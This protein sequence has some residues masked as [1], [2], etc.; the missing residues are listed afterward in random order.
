MEYKFSETEKTK[1]RWKVNQQDENDGEQVDHPRLGMMRVKRD[2]GEELIIRN[3]DDVTGKPIDVDFK[4]ERD[5]F[6]KQSKYAKK[7]I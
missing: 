6:L 7:E 5:K 2:D 3:F 1:G 4:L